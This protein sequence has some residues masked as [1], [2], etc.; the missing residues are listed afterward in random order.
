MHSLL[1]LSSSLLGFFVLQIRPLLLECSL[2]SI[3]IPK[4]YDGLLNFPHKERVMNTG[5]LLMF[6][7][8]QLLCLALGGLSLA[9]L[10]F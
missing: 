7:V 5:F 8:T 4:D 2:K 6:S 10:F 9:K 3:C 1:G